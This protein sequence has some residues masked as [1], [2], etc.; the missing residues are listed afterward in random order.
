M[1]PVILKICSAVTKDSRVLCFDCDAFPLTTTDLFSIDITWSFHKCHTN[2]LHGMKPWKSLFSSSWEKSKLFPVLVTPGSLLL[3]SNI[4]YFYHM[5]LPLVV[6]LRTEGYLVLC[7]KV[8]KMTSMFCNL[9][10]RLT[11]PSI[12]SYSWLW[13]KGKGTW[14]NVPW[15]KVRASKDPHSMES[16]RSLSGP[17]DVAQTWSTHLPGTKLSTGCQHTRKQGWGQPSPGT[18]C[19]NAISFKVTTPFFLGQD[20][21]LVEVKK[22]SLQV[23]EGSWMLHSE[24]K[25][26]LQP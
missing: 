17:E 7:L 20:D 26:F 16:H 9:L 18:N 2:R 25:C 21:K 15:Q 1:A 4:L 5:T 8:P 23:Q 10:W 11:H 3:K 13:L 19:N 22:S 12:C 24:S 6:N 14:D